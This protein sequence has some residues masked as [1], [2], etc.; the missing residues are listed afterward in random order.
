[1]S[2]RLENEPELVLQGAV[3]Y[4]LKHRCLLVLDLEGATVCRDPVPGSN[5]CVD[6]CWRLR[7]LE[8]DQQHNLLRGTFEHQPPQHRVATVQVLVNHSSHDSWLLLAE[9]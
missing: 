1:M 9:E 8:V 5:W 4:Y 6:L 7:E 2:E 3:L